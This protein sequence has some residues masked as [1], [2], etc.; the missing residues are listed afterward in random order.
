LIGEHES[1]SLAAPAKAEKKAD[2]VEAAG[3]KSAPAA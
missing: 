3:L 1:R 2:L